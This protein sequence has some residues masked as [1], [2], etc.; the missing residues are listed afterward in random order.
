MRSV[1]PLQQSKPFCC[2]HS[3]CCMQR[4]THSCHSLTTHE[5]VFYSI[6]GWTK[7]MQKAADMASNSPS[8]KQEILTGEK[9]VKWDKPLNWNCYFKWSDL[10]FNQKYYYGAAAGY[11]HTQPDRCKTISSWSG[12]GKSWAQRAYL[13]TYWISKFNRIM[14]EEL[15]SRLSVFYVCKWICS[16]IHAG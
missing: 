4:H 6:R 5:I 2:Q 12:V 13:L 1:N 9:L 16:Y 14:C 8:S 7:Q 11:T 10:K 3:P 15:F